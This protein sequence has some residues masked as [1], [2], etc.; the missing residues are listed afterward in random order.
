MVE[1]LSLPST[2]LTILKVVP[3]QMCIYWFSNMGFPLCQP[4]FGALPAL[5]EYPIRCNVSIPRVCLI[6]CLGKTSHVT[7]KIVLGF[8]E[9]SK[10]KL[11]LL[12]S[13]LCH[14]TPL[15]HCLKTKCFS[16]IFKS[17]P[18]EGDNKIHV[19]SLSFVS[20]KVLSEPCTSLVIIVFH[21]W[22]FLRPMKKWKS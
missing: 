19:K 3:S 1:K 17:F 5:Q 2:V 7:E 16:P 12:I 13:L 9:V 4:K 14:D 15:R 21:W 11:S 10:E 22:H 6:H 20:A 8:S 18:S